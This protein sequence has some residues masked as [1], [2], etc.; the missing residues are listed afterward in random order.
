[1]EAEQLKKFSPCELL[2]AYET[3][4]NY[5]N[6]L[7]KQWTGP[8]PTGKE[9]PPKKWWDNCYKRA[10]KFSTDPAAYCGALWYHG[11][12]KMRESFGKGGETMAE[13]KQKQQ[14]YDPDAEVEHAE[15]EEVKQDTDTEEEEKPEEE[16]QE[17]EEEEKQ[18][19]SPDVTEGTMGDVLQ[20]I[21]EALQDIKTMISRLNEPEEEEAP[22]PEDTE[23]SMS[24]IDKK[25]EKEVKKHLQELGLTKSAEVKKPKENAEHP[26]QKGEQ[27][28]MQE[29]SKM[30]WREV[31]DYVAKMRGE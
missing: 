18:D 17:N 12:E 1:M 19:V 13:E 30:T 2:K 6:E 3:I 5:L 28:T 20:Q 11:P 4:G 23:I 10:E 15:H 14:D 25:V 24:D 7:S 21:L 26:I 16:E 29:L 9:R 27:L 31:E 22:A 8:V